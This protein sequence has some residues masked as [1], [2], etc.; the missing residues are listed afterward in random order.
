MIII[1]LVII[2]LRRDGSEQNIFQKLLLFK[3]P[4]SLR[5]KATADEFSEKII[6]IIRSK[7]LK[8]DVIIPIPSSSKDR[9]SDGSARLAKNISKSLGIEDGTGW[10]KRIKKYQ[11]LTLQVQDLLNNISIAFHVQITLLIKSIII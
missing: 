1:S 5:Y 2:K 4:N 6:D 11:N 8:F 3:S 9:V 10:L 7:N